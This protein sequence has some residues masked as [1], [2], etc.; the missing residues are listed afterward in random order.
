MLE[1]IVTSVIP[2]ADCKNIDIIFDTNCEELIMG[3]DPDKIERIV[4]NLISNAIK[5]SK[6]IQKYI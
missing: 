4:L 3:V 5:F 1:N 6:I 2:Y